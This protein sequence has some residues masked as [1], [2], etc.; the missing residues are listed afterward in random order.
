MAFENDKNRTVRDTGAAPDK[1]HRWSGQEDTRG[2]A[3]AWMSAPVLDN[4]QRQTHMK[5]RSISGGLT[6]VGS[7]LGDSGAQGDE[8]ARAVT[9]APYFIAVCEMTRPQWVTLA[10]TRPWEDVPSDR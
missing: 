5:M 6:Q 2:T 9:L 8:T 7:G 3:T 1:S 10:G 4:S